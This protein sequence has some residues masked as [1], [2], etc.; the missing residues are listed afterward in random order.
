MKHSLPRNRAACLRDLPEIHY[1]DRDWVAHRA[2]MDRLTREQKEE[3]VA[4]ERA[5]GRPYIEKT[6]RAIA[7]W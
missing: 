4:K 5:T 2:M 7:R 3:L 6:R 1:R